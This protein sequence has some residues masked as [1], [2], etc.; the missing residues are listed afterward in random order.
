VKVFE[1]FADVNIQFVVF[2]VVTPCSDVV[3]YHFTLKM[4]AARPS[5]TLVSCVTV[6]RGQNAEDLDR[7]KSSNT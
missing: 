2:W 5:E 1:V 6:T 3:R 7:D 4:E